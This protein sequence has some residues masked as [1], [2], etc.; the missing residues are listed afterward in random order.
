MT[1]TFK[2][3]SA[4]N[5]T[6]RSL[7]QR[8]RFR[9]MPIFIL[10]VVLAMIP[11]AALPRIR[12][13]EQLA[14]QRSDVLNALSRD[15]SDLLARSVTDVAALATSSFVRAYND[16]VVRVENPV[17]PPARLRLAQR[18][19]LRAL[20]DLV[21]R[22]PERYLSIRYLTR[23]NAVWGE[24]V[25]NAGGQITLGS[26]FRARAP[27]EQDDSFI[28][29]VADETN[30][31]IRLGEANFEDDY[32]RIY[33]PIPSRSGEVIGGI[34]AL[35]VNLI[36]FNA[37]LSQ[38]NDN[39]S[40]LFAQ[41]RRSLLIN[42]RGQL[43]A[44]SEI[45]QDFDDARTFNSQ[46]PGSAQDPGNVVNIT[47]G[48]DQYSTARIDPY[49]GLDLPWRLALIDDTP[50]LLSSTN[51]FS[52][53]S[54]S[55]VLITGVILLLVLDRILSS[56][57]SPLESVVTR[58]AERLT[59]TE[60]PRLS[61]SQVA[62]VSAREN[63]RNELGK[64]ISEDAQVSTLMNAI[65][66]ATSRISGLAAELE[67]QTR[68]RARDIDVAARIGRATAQLIDIDE[69]IT[70]AIQFIIIELGVYHAQ[71]FLVDDLGQ[72]AVLS[73][74]YGE[75]G[76]KL[77]GAGHKLRVGSETVVGRASGQ[78][79]TFV[80]NDTRDPQ[81]RHGFNALLPD[82]RAEIALPLL[83]GDRVI[84]V[85]DIQSVQMGFFTDEDLAVYELLSDQLAVAINKAQLLRQIEQRIEQTNAQNRQF[86]RTAW[87]D[88][89]DP[90]AKELSYTYNLSEVKPATQPRANNT[91]TSG[92][93]MPISVRG[94][95][96]GELSAAPPADEMLTENHR[97]LLRSVAERVALAVENARLFTESQSSLS[98]ARILYELSRNL[99]ETVSF[100]G[101]LQAMLSTVV[102]NSHRSLLWLFPDAIT[103]DTLPSI[104]V[105][106]S[107][108]S[109][110]A[111]IPTDQRPVS[112]QGV[113]YD[114]EAFPFLQRFE[115]EAIVLIQDAQNDAR[116]DPST[117]ALMKNT[118]IESAVFVPLYVRS[119]WLGILL[120]GFPEVR[121]FSLREQRLFPAM[122]DPL[123]I[124]TDNRLLFERNE[125]TSTRNE[126]LYSV[127]RSINNAKT[128]SDLVAAAFSTTTNMK[129]SFSLALLEGEPDESGW[130]T[131]QRVM[132]YSENLAVQEINFRHRIRIG[133]D[134]PLRERNA[135]VIVEDDSTGSL[136]EI[137]MRVPWL[138]HPEDVCFMAVYPLFNA[139]GPIA[140]FYIT[141]VEPHTLT[142]DEN[143]TYGAITGQMSTQLQNRQLLDSTAEALEDTNRLYVAT[144][145]ISGAQSLDDIYFATADHISKPALTA[146]RGVE[147]DLRV[148][149]WLARPDAN[150]NAPLLEMAYEWS[151]NNTPS[152]ILD[153]GRRTFW[154]RDEMPVIDV[155]DGGQSILLNVTDSVT[156][157]TPEA[158]IASAL[159]ANGAAAALIVQIESRSYWFGAIIVQTDKP[160]IF[161][162]R[163]TTFVETTAG[164][165]ALAMENK[166]L[167]AKTEA[168]LHE[169]G[170]QYQAS[171]ALSNAT[172]SQDVLNILVS[173]LI[174]AD[175]SHAFIVELQNSTWES[176][177]ASVRV[178]AEWMRDG[179]SLLNNNILMPDE[180]SAWALLS[181]PDVI[182]IND[183][184]S[185]N[186]H[187]ALQ[188]RGVD[189]L[190]LG[191]LDA[192]SLVVIPLRVQNRTIGAIWISGSEPQPF[193]DSDTRIF[194]SFGEQA[195]LSLDASRLLEQ[196]NRRA[197]QL[198]T[199][200]EVS[201]AASQILD[202]KELLPRLV[203]L[204][205]IRFGYDH[206]QIFLMDDNDDYA[207]LRASTG[208][209]GKKLLSLRHKL[210]KGSSSVIGQ[211]TQNGLPI[212]ASDTAEAQVVHA[213]NPLLPDTR[214]EMALPL[215]IKNKIIGALDVQ[216]NNANA[217]TPDDISALTTLAAQISVAIENANLYEKSQQEANRMGF[218]FEITTSAAAA[219]TV[220]DALQRVVDSLD[221]I[222]T[223]RVVVVYIKQLYADPLGNMFEA[224]DAIVFSGLDFNKDN[225]PRI[226]I[227]E[228]GGGALGDVARTRQ[229]RVIR[230]TAADIS[231]HPLL[232]NSAS[233]LIVPLVGGGELLGLILLEG[234]TANE[235]GLETVQLVQTLAGSLSAIIQN[236]QFL[237]RLK[238]AN[239]ELRDLDKLKS[240]FLANM[241][242]ELRTPLNSIIGFS[243]MM[244]KGMSG[245]LSEMQEQ[246][247]NTIFTSGNHLLTVIN[248]ILDQAKIAA[249]KMTV[250]V[251]EFDVKP[252]LEAV[253]SIGLGLVKDKPVDLR[254][255]VAPNMPK[256]FGDKVR[257]RQVML[258]LVSNASKFT[259]QGTVIIR[260]YPVHEDGKVWVRVDVIDSGIGIDER[261]MPLLFEPFR[262]VDSSLTRTAGGTGLG[263]PIARSLMQL[264]GGTLEVSSIIN[265]GSTF[266]IRIPTEPMQLEEEPSSQFP[267]ATPQ[268]TSE[269]AAIPADSKLAMPPRTQ[270]PLMDAKRQVMV[271]EDNPDMVDQYRRTLQ[272]EGFEVI[273]ASSMLEAR[274]IAPT[275]QPTLIIM[276]VDFDGGEGWE[277]LEEL[278][279]RDDTSDIPVIIATLSEENERAEAQGAFAFLQRP[280]APD[281]LIEAVMRAEKAANIPRILLIDDQDDA[282][283]L[284]GELL[285]EHGNFRVYTARS[286][287][288][289][290]MQVAFRRPQLVIL[291]LRM[292][293]MDGFAVLQEL[294]QNP[295]TSHIPV[296]IVTNDDTLKDD[297]RQRLT[298]VHVVQK[299]AISLNE[300]DSFIRGV[301]E[302]LRMN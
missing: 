75:A 20:A 6:K 244:L 153:D 43:I 155:L 145:E 235:F 42:S 95:V 161:S 114:L 84:G 291:D 158:A 228:K 139:K 173:S 252:E 267:V 249:G 208:E 248:D 265:T 262:Q 164:Q 156:P 90:L 199:S 207:E 188:S 136:P 287:M 288:E 242:H 230:D 163:Y 35:D 160:E 203:E 299:A 116:L 38:V 79:R 277:L 189:S 111:I 278:H 80:V 142:A 128:Y 176:L 41:A 169:S 31:E 183:S 115:T 109:N 200:A 275:L 25:N 286:G 133:P 154:T 54:V 140:L 190:I 195:S 285:R 283:K 272:R 266:T 81:A 198:Q 65:E 138:P 27:E 147:Q 82:T 1:A 180:F 293:E 97:N 51:A 15:V 119:E 227:A 143:S 294:R 292:P 179:G 144:R 71:V 58:A 218:L 233:A 209:A 192:K 271:V 171:R 36:A 48:A 55:L 258:N 175:S 129:T 273:V 105:L 174:G 259:R 131:L 122:I 257:V 260:A 236:A 201:N 63:P 215:S 52:L 157:H 289:G 30:N 177:G 28:A 168:A 225:A 146:A 134:S 123:S 98:E 224:L 83:I 284:L 301:S 10:L 213:P 302:N 222:L 166:L 141:S 110:D 85:L 121:D 33:A 24:V 187:I 13:L 238:R 130:P 21:T 113:E 66:L 88:F 29:L 256:V 94:E 68:R 151:S 132:A 212:I 281:Q 77:L 49:I 46:N 210:R 274:A 101:V 282:L 72:N 202:L 237:D 96:I 172:T 216:S 270:I 23:D 89:E 8:M 221:G 91:M 47:N 261:D 64:A 231:Y 32:I 182:T 297:E 300:Y 137:S 22:N 135:D 148:M 219:T 61:T 70:R 240:D 170:L 290:L 264:M 117:R 226:R 102:N 127:S 106:R 26:S 104:A 263:L 245:Q 59:T 298:Q 165:L 100:D 197:Q 186:A 14:T 2:R 276:D 268:S 159:H 4:P 194:Q 17:A 185:E 39:A 239:E 107:D 234:T 223:P 37:P 74:S 69:L 220:N 214:S 103:E 296:M 204:V 112:L 18:D 3:I 152:R 124:A 11:A 217:F 253:K 92:L 56:T 280:Y 211:V 19:M 279:A 229:V 60:I 205:K 118:N 150:V 62:A 9:L 57:L 45:D 44:G 247:L 149:I 87:E 251:E 167:F 16:E 206:A 241:S 67:A 86:T 53:I 78:K 99:N 295:E 255:E 50:L 5:P 93:R 108:Y 34:L 120:I 193:R 184:D 250:S 232:P 246:D 73:Y 76:R 181:S 12:E 178:V 269:M 125:A 126:N 254:M 40:S 7:Q 191:A 243:R 162:E 196:T